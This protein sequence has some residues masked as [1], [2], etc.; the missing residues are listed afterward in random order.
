M[1]WEF[2]DFRGESDHDEASLLM[3]FAYGC[4]VAVRRHRECIAVAAQISE[5]AALFYNKN[6]I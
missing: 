4:V 5:M 6:L 3:G 1:S 2:A